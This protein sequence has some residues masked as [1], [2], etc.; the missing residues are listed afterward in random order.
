MLLSYH[1]LSILHLRKL[2]DVLSF[3]KKKL[4]GLSESFCCGNTENAAVTKFIL[5]LHC[6]FSSK[7]GQG[8]PPLS[9]PDF[10]KGFL[11]HYIISET[12]TSKHKLL[13]FTCFELIPWTKVCFN[14]IIIMSQEGT[15]TWLF[16]I[17]WFSSA[18]S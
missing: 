7:H 11:N 8:L 1:L 14:G 2:G 17:L 6:R 18:V 10:L 13:F 9:V 5:K 12:D 16:K 4:L 15:Q 3:L